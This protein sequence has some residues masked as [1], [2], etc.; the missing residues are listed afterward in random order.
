METPQITTVAPLINGVEYGWASV[1]MMIAGMQTV[2]VTAFDFQEKQTKENIYGI[3]VKPVGRGYGNIE[4]NGSITLLRSEIAA[5]RES[6]P[7]KKLIDIAPFTIVLKYIPTAGE[8]MVTKIFKNVEFTND[9]Y[10]MKQ[11]DTKEEQ[12]LDL[13][14]GSIEEE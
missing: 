4:S 5:I 13:V 8:K 7:T 12:Q 14:I 2:G 11:G 6:V 10:G 9:D 3:G 1:N